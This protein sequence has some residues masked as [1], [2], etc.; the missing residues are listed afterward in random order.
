MGTKRLVF[1]IIIVL[2]LIGGVVGG[3]YY[4]LCGSKQAAILQEEMAKVLEKDI[5]DE[6]IDMKI[7]SLGNYGKVEL[8]VKEYLND[9]RTTFLSMQTI[10]DTKDQEEILSESNIAADPEG[11]TIVQQKVEEKRQ[12][13]NN[14]I[15][16]TQNIRNSDT[17]MK[18]IDG[19][20][21]KENY[22]DVFK[23]I[24]LDEAVESKL[25]VAEE[26]IKAEQEDA[27]ERVKKL[28]NT[29]DFLV[30]NARYWELSEGKIQFTNTNKLAEYLEVLN[31]DK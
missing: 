1:A 16:K 20:N 13:L 18:S 17:I 28:E 11:L 12:E 29:V 4:L 19:K 7:K 22:Y 3:Y 9:V 24:V 21:V 25:L 30:K 14:L 10:C 23:N 8:A 6:E 5:L 26:R 2:L 15:T 31:G 27:E